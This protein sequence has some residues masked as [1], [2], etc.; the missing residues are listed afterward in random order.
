MSKHTRLIRITSGVWHEGVWGEL[1]VMVGGF[2]R[3]NMAAQSSSELGVACEP[4][5]KI[6]S[7]TESGSAL[8]YIRF[9]T[10]A[11]APSGPAYPSRG[12]GWAALDRRSLISVRLH[13]H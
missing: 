13:S 6:R 10:A 1:Q 5:R 4:H 2:P 11:E 12:A 8:R 9:T 3:K 7:A